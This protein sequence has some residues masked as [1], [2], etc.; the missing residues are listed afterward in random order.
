MERNITP[1]LALIFKNWIKVTPDRRLS[2][3]VSVKDL[4]TTMDS[5][6]LSLHTESGAV[7]GAADCICSSLAS[8]H[9]SE[10]TTSHITAFTLVC[11][12]L[13]VHLI[14]L[15]TL[16]KLCF[17]AVI[18]TMFSKIPQKINTESIV[19]SH[20]WE[21]ITPA[22]LFPSLCSLLFFIFQ[23]YQSSLSLFNATAK[24]VS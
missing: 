20:C 10:Q 22:G 17:D 21:L 11:T 23:S 13:F 24:F 14:P 12:P 1:H 6:L 4:F 3:M 8:L 19:L 7:R 18:H 9:Y 15:T 2:D 5:S 16:V